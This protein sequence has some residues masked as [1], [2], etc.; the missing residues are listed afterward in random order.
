MNEELFINLSIAVL[1][2]IPLPI[3]IA[4]IRRK[5]LVVIQRK[6]TYLVLLIA[7]VEIVSYFLWTKKINNHPIYHFYSILEFLFILNIYSSSLSR[8]NSKKSIYFLGIVFIL[9]ALGNMLFLQNLFEFNS[10][11]TTTSA[12]LILLLCLISITTRILQN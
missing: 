9:F 6:L 2:L 8:W 1:F 3:V 12:I 5:Q 11:V 7:V 10:N 4:L